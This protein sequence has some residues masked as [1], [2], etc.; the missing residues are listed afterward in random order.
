LPGEP[1]KAI[2]LLMSGVIQVYLKLKDGSELVIDYLGIGSFIGQYSVIEKEILVCGFR[3]VSSH[4]C[5][6]IVLQGESLDAISKYN[7]EIKTI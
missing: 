4:G 5:L 3:A 7:S 1:C 6:L 2:Y